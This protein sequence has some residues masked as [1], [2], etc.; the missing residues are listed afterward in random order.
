MKVDEGE[1]VEAA[2]E[3]AMKMMVHP[4]VQLEAQVIVPQEKVERHTL[5]QVQAQEKVLIMQVVEE[6]VVVDQG[7]QPE[8]LLDTALHLV[9]T[10][11]RL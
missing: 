11:D 5:R 10:M 9:L 3:V 4:P 6:E 7:E 8:P 2:A 1:G